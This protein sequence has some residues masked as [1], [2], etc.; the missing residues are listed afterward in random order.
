MAEKK[1]HC[2][3][4]LDAAEKTVREAGGVPVEVC[5]RD[6]GRMEVS[7]VIAGSGSDRVHTFFWDQQESLTM[8]Y[9]FVRS[10]T[11]RVIVVPRTNPRAG[12]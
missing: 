9:N 8:L 12:K 3:A 6:D 2:P 5:Y 1:K 10:K 7:F 11:P 4:E